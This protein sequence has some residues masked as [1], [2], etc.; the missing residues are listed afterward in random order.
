LSRADLRSDASGPPGSRRIPGRPTQGAGHTSHGGPDPRWAEDHDDPGDRSVAC[1]TGRLT[2][3]RSSSAALSL[4]AVTR[5]DSPCEGNQSSLAAHE[6]PGQHCYAWRTRSPVGVDV[7]VDQAR[8]KGHVARSA[9]LRPMR[10]GSLVLLVLNYSRGERLP[11]D[12]RTWGHLIVA[13]IF[14]N[15]L[16]FA[17]FSI[18]EQTVDSGVAGFSTRQPLVGLAHRHHH[19]HGAWTSSDSFERATPWF[20][21]RLLIFAPWRHSGL[22]S[23]VP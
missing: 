12:K 22:A 18:G 14:C 17:L 13:A 15:A 7:P 6:Q 4:R 20:R 23:W 9:H 3:S 11:R 19:R 8:A 2:S 21:G 5:D 16:P 10:P 1:R